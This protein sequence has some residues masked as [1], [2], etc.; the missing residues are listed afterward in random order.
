MVVLSTARIALFWLLLPAWAAAADDTPDGSAY[1]EKLLRWRDSVEFML[2]D[3]ILSP[4]T[5]ADRESFAGLDYFPGDPALVVTA[6]LEG[7]ADSS[8]FAMP[9]FNGGT[10]AY[11]HFATL[12]ALVAGQPVRLKAFRREDGQ[13]ARDFLLIPFTDPTNGEETYAGG[14]YLEMELPDAGEGELPLDFNRAAN[15]LCAYDPSYACPIPP[16]ENRL[17]MPIRAGEKIYPDVR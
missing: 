14:R 3:P 2:R 11:S 17:P 13:V 1:G 6:R 10:I 7:A 4:L 16:R 8:T 15:P 12:N 5:D 9:T